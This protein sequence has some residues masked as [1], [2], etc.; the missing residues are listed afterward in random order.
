M[1]E[2]LETAVQDLIGERLDEGVAARP[3]ELVGAR[4]DR[5][6]ALPFSV[7]RIQ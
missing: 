3:A 1:V 6:E 7:K 2:T 4:L 5:R